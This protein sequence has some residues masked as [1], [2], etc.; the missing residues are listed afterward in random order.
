MTEQIDP[1]DLPYE[2]ARDEL[3]ALVRELETG[4]VPLEDALKILERGDAL[5]RRCQEVLDVATERIMKAT[6]PLVGAAGTQPTS[7]DDASATS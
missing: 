3:M 4:N 5:S 6:D 2:A 1:Q 7:P